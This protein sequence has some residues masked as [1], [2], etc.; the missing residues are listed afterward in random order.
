MNL[1]NKQ[2]AIG[3]IFEGFEHAFQ[4]LLKIAAVFST[5]KQCAHIQGVDRGIGQNIRHF[6]LGNA[7]CQAFCNCG[8]AYTGFTH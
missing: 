2:N 7:P 6:A 4:A 8:F 3:I 1:V 5:S